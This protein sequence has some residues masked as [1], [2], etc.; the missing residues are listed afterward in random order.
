MALQ[1]EKDRPRRTVD[2]A[3]WQ[4]PDQVSYWLIAEKRNNGI[5]V[6]TIRTDDVQEA[7]P[8][9][10][11]EEEA[12]IFFRIGFPDW[13]RV[14]RMAGKG[15][16]CRGVGLGALWPLR[17]RYDGGPRPVAGDGS[18]GDGCAGFAPP[19]TINEPNRGQKRWIP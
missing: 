2:H 7:L 19:G 3:P 1:M 15:E 18:R 16:R 17:G 12:K 9:F 5:E 14:R 6:L 8:I 4:P 10:S 11:S 13:R